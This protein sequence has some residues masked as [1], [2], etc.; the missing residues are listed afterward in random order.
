MLIESSFVMLGLVV[1]LLFRI[2][3]ENETRQRLLDARP[4]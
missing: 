3:S 1:W 2:L 4:R